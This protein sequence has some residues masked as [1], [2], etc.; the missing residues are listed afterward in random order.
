M[1]TINF[2]YDAEKYCVKNFLDNAGLLSRSV[3]SD[4]REGAPHDN[5]DLK[6]INVKGDMATCAYNK[7]DYEKG[8]LI[9][10]TVEI[11][12]EYIHLNG[13]AAV[14][15]EYE[16]ILSSIDEEKAAIIRGLV[17]E[18]ERDAAVAGYN[19]CI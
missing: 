12:V 9:E 19:G 2:V 4:S 18:K 17:W 15:Y 1:K 16:K 11:P 5:K 10:L 8:E 6:I 7:Y 14:D 13:Y 3:W